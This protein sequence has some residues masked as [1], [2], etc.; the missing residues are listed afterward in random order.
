MRILPYSHPKYAANSINSVTLISI[1]RLTLIFSTQNMDDYSWAYGPVLT[2]ESAEVGATIIALSVPALKP[3]LR[4][5]T[6]GG[7]AKPWT[8]EGTTLASTADVKPSVQPSASRRR[9]SVFLDSDN[10]MDIAVNNSINTNDEGGQYENSNTEDTESTKGI[11][12][13]MSVGKRE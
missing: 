7:K 11:F 13:N 10:E 2:I 6:T 12:V 1:T 9:D 8:S 4:F 5:I 3:L